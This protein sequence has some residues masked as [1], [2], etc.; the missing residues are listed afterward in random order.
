ML[1]VHPAC[2]YK[3]WNKVTQLEVTKVKAEG[4]EEGTEQQDKAVLLRLES[5]CHQPATSHLT[6][7]KPE[8]PPWPVRL[9]PIPDPQFTALSDFPPS[10]WLFA[11]P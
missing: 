4:L 11:L 2:V 6:W 10:L 7:E 3:L 9:L 8:A 5:V 1:R